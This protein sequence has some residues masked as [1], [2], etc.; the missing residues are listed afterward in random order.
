[1]VT[2]REGGVERLVSAEEAFLLFLLKRGLEGDGTATRATLIAIEIA[3]KRRTIH[4]DPIVITHMMVNPG[5]VTLA[6]EHLRM[7]RK[8]DPY[9]ETARASLGRAAEGTNGGCRIELGLRYGV[10]LE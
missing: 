10:S 1:M 7:A 8:L 4:W 6:T 2:I 5:S 9:R 3:A